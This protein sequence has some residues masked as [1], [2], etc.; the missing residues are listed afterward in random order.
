MSVYFTN[1]PKSKCHIF[2]YVD[3]LSASVATNVVDKKNM[4][5]YK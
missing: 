3:I 1:D 5:P 4:Q 2:K